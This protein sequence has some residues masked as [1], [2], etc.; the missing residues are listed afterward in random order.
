MALLSL[1]WLPN[2]P[3]APNFL[4]RLSPP[5]PGYPLG[6]DHLG[7]DLLARVMAGAQNALY[8]GLISVGIGLGLGA[9]LGLLG[10]YLGGRLDRALGFF[11]G[12]FLCSPSPT[13]SYSL[14]GHTEPRGC[15][16]H[17]RHWA[18]HRTGFLPP[19]KGGCSFCPRTSLRRGSDSSGSQLSAS[20][21]SAYP[22]ANLGFYP[23][24]RKP[25][26]CGGNPD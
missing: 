17:A 3:N 5:S 8:V 11:S 12:G 7:R 25:C 16:F 19:S 6:T 23:G 13:F 21:V 10:G 14:R 15:E 24:A 20:Y 4:H 9:L 1:F 2:D 22:T 26:L 18:G